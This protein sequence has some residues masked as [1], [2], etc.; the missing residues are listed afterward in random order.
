M[1]GCENFSLLADLVI[2]SL[3]L[4]M[5]SPICLSCQ[6]C[7]MMLLILPVASSEVSITPKTENKA[8][9]RVCPT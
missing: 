8:Y 1:D 5:V 9:L 3:T 2:E 4:Y 6:G 7:V